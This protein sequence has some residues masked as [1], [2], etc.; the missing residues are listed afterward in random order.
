MKTPKQKLW[1][2][3]HNKVATCGECRHFIELKVLCRGYS[4]YPPGA[5]NPG[6]N[7]LLWLMHIGHI[8]RDGRKQR[9]PVDRFGEIFIATRAQTLFPVVT[10]GMGRQCDDGGGITHFP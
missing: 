9:F 6:L 1:E 7:F 4:G 3:L 2:I 10:H 8:A 5:N